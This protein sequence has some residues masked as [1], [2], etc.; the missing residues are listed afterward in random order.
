MRLVIFIMA[1]ALLFSV[2][3][4]NRGILFPRFSSI[5]AVSAS[6][7]AAVAEQMVRAGEGTL[8][9]DFHA[10]LSGAPQPAGASAWEVYV[11]SKMFKVQLQSKL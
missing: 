7:T 11:R 1:M 5:Q 4:L 9:D 6:L 10:V 3:E 2:Q 8:P